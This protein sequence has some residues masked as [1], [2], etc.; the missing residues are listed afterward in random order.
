MRKIHV[1]DIGINSSLDYPGD[2]PG[3]S[4]AGVG[5]LRRIVVSGKGEFDEGV[6]AR[7]GG[8][9]DAGG[10]DGK[11]L[12]KSYVKDTVTTPSINADQRVKLHLARDKKTLSA[13]PRT[14]AGVSYGHTQ[15]RPLRAALVQTSVV[16]SH[17]GL[18]IFLIVFVS[19]GFCIALVAIGSF[20]RS[21]ERRISRADTDS[22]MQTRVSKMRPSEVGPLRSRAQSKN[23]TSAPDAVD[24]AEPSRLD[25]ISPRS[26]ME[27]NGQSLA[28]SDR[29]AVQ[30]PLKANGPD[31][32]SL[33]STSSPGS[34]G[35]HAAAIRI[36][37]VWRGSVRRVKF[38]S[39]GSLARNVDEE[40][41]TVR[42]VGA[43]A[44]L[45][46]QR[47]NTKKQSMSRASDRS[48]PKRMPTAS[49]RFRMKDHTKM[50]TPEEVE[51]YA[52][53][54]CIQSVWRGHNSRGKLSTDFPTQEDV[55]SSARNAEEERSNIEQAT[56]L[57]A[58]AK[59]K[60][61]KRNK[62]RKQSPPGAPD[63][64]SPT[65]APTIPDR[66]RPKDL[67]KVET[68]GEVESYAAAAC[69]Q[70]I[71]RGHK[72]RDAIK[73][74][75]SAKPKWQR[76]AKP[77]KNTLLSVESMR[78]SDDQSSPRQRFHSVPDS[79]EPED[80]SKETFLDDES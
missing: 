57:V 29:G 55:V 6:Y 44:I 35:S 63:Q 68:P 24:V 42:G 77:K 15:E 60:A 36:Q 64:S 80:L 14:P 2:S 53:A 56:F 5:I 37:A 30:E 34:V 8:L 52:A 72:S 20:Y 12:L 9:H 46:G 1:D 17:Q 23:R 19:F 74:V 21:S 59:P 43:S 50:D 16:F 38:A 71:W 45:K 28:Q 7:I 61:P 40:N 22:R 51:S 48:L 18:Y 76:K 32:T 69:I 27:E 4:E 79:F 11:S 66:F 54:T 70:S 13:G 49:D 33:A 58:G 65:L 78:N 73:P 31:Y 39:T 25:A 67:M 3:E 26:D 47:K 41:V 62:G 10:S 75:V